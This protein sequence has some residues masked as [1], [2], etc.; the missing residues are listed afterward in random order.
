MSEQHILD[1]MERGGIVD[2]RTNAIAA[3]VLSEVLAIVIY[4]IHVPDGGKYVTLKGYLF[5]HFF[6]SVFSPGMDSLIFA[7][8]FV[9]AAAIRIAMRA[10][11]PPSRRA[12]TST[13]SPS[14]PTPSG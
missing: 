8:A 6:A 10:C 2:N 7:L 5:E 12:T 1:V 4:V 14:R 9:L 13:G 3:Y 11:E